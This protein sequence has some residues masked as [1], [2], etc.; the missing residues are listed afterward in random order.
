MSSKPQ[1]ALPVL[2]NGDAGTPA[3][4]S[5]GDMRAAHFCNS[6]GKVQP[7][8]PT[9][10][11]SFFGLPRRLNLEVAALERE[12][13]ALSRR[14]HPDLYVHA[15]EAEQAWSLEQT[16]KLNDAYRTLRDPVLRSEYL[17]RLEGIKSGEES[18][19]ATERARSSGRKQPAVPPELLEA[20]FDLNL[21]LEEF[22]GGNSGLRSELEQARHGFEQQRDAATA[23][24]QSC[25]NEWDALMSREERRRVLDR[26]LGVL[27]RRRYIEHLL[28]ELSAAVAE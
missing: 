16:S 2:P 10:F 13:Y 14:L 5:C 26:M 12:M 7:P 8:A 3:C 21:Q 25:W 24:L 11:F 18:K 20:V 1:P 15:S 6:C 27:N 22:R 9:D 19:L 23:E 28:E 17:L 4:W